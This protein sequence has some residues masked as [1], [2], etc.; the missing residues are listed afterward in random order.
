VETRLDEII[1]KWRVAWEQKDCPGVQAR[2]N[3]WRISWKNIA[4]IRKRMPIAIHMEVQ[5]RVMIDLLEVW[6]ADISREIR[7]ALGPRP[8]LKSVWIPEIHLG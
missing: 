7:V 1:T 3:L 4:R 6:S 2:L 5:R 8:A